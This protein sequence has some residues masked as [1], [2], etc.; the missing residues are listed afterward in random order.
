[1]TENYMKVVIAVDGKV[2]A[3]GVDLS[4]IGLLHVVCM[5][6]FLTVA[7]SD[8]SSVV[9]GLHS[10]HRLLHTS[11]FQFTFCCHRCFLCHVPSYTVLL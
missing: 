11:L 9:R 3:D 7:N 8:V 1:M 4:V 6:M 5:T 10:K 2:S